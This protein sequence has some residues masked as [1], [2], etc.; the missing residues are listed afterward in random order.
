MISVLTLTYQRHHILEEAIQSYLLQQHGSSEMVVVNDSPDVQYVFTHPNVTV[1]N[2]PTR[3]SSVGKK[4]EWAYKQCKGEHIYRLDDDDLLAPGALKIVEEEIKKDPGYEIYRSQSHYLFDSN[5]YKGIHGSINNG[6][7]Y[8]RKFL[9][10]IKFP[11]LSG[12]EDMYITF[13]THANIKEY[14]RITMIY[15]WGMN[16]YHISGMGIQPPAMIQ[17]RT[18]KSV[19][20]ERG[21]IDLNPQFR[22]D[23]WNLLPK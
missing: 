14:P 8:T 18:D 2:H 4:L 7:V 15:R 5:V 23:Y 3:F 6:N 10:R 19:E 17:M 21:V 13:R 22:K 12:D 16:T 11:N 20:G 1:I 9:D